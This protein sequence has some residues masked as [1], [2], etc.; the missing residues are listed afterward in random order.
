MVLNQ[1][2]S[3]KS[4][5]Q[6]TASMKKRTGISADKEYW[7]QYIDYQA[8]TCKTEFSDANIV[9]CMNPYTINEN[10][11]IFQHLTPATEKIQL[12]SCFRTGMKR[13][14]RKKDCEKNTLE[15]NLFTALLQQQASVCLFPLYSGS[16]PPYRFPV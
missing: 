15:L 5:V 14:I 16:I 8:F 11:T 3:N 9:I 7:L 1:F 2:A 10:L 13:I 4:M 6:Q 12:L